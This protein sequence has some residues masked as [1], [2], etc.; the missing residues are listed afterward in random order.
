MHIIL[1]CLIELAKNWRAIA[2][3]SGL[4]LAKGFS[5]K[6]FV[7]ELAD[8]AIKFWWVAA[9]ACLV[10]LGRECIKEYFSLRREQ[11]R[12]SQKK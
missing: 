11:M 12:Y 6:L 4:V 9:L 7:K 2:A 8:S 5:S 10:L 3:L 1:K